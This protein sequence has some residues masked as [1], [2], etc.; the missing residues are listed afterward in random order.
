LYAVILSKDKEWDIKAM[1]LSHLQ[2]VKNPNGLD[3]LESA[4]N[5]VDKMKALDPQI[6]VG[7]DILRK[8]E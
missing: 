2:V 1:V 7:S 5:K 8:L 4:Q 6:Y 3:Q